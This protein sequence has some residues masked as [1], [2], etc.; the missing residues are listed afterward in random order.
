MYKVQPHQKTDEA[1]YVAGG[2]TP[3]LPLAKRALYHY[4]TTA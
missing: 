2:W 4:V 3:D 1:I